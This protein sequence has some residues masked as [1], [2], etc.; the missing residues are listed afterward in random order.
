MFVSLVE[1]RQIPSFAIQQ[2]SLFTENWQWEQCRWTTI[3]L[4]ICK[5]LVRASR[6]LFMLLLC[7]F[8]RVD[9]K[10]SVI[11]Q[12]VT[13]KPLHSNVFCA[14]CQASSSKLILL[15]EKPNSYYFPM[16]L[17]VNLILDPSGLSLGFC[18]QWNKW[19]L[20]REHYLPCLISDSPYDTETWH[21][22]IPICLYIY[23]WN[24]NTVLHIYIVLRL[25]KG[26]DR[27]ATEL[28]G[29]KVL[30]L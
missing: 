22:Y 13:L 17:S 9:H 3:S 16:W 2:E 25:E 18:W 1:L 20:W 30:L 27:S 21:S 14:I 19:N 8:S 26:N 10:A 5:M 4:Q 15:G 24:S 28:P 7:L 23:L 29:I 12:F 6:A 11:L